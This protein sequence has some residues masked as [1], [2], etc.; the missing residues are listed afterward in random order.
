MAKRGGKLKNLLVII[1]QMCTII[2]KLHLT[3]GK[4]FGTEGVEIVYDAMLPPSF[5]L[6]YIDLDEGNFIPQKGTDKIL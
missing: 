5:I 1:C 6:G 4:F 3:E 2:A